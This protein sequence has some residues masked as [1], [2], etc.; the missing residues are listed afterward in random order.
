MPSNAGQYCL[1]RIG[2]FGPAG[3]ALGA[4]DAKRLQN[5]YSLVKTYFGMEKDFD[6][7]K[8]YSNDFL[9]KNVKMKK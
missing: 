7:A 9:D 6:I 3:V 5:D 2:P 4:F 8:V 1:R